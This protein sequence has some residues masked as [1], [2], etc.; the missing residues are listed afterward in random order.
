MIMEHIFHLSFREH[1]I[2]GDQRLD[3]YFG[4]LSA[5]YETFTPEQV[6]CNVRTLWNYGIDYEKPY[7]N[8]LC[9]VRKEPL[10]RKPQKRASRK[11][12]KSE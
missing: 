8:K 5:I 1:P 3:F 4:S 6:G 2:E 10:G 11:A 7:H 12:K 9:S